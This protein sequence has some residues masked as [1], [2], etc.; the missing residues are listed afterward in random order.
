MTTLDSRIGRILPDLVAWRRDLHAHPEIAF[1]EHRTSA[2]IADKLRGFGLEAHTGLAGTGVVGVLRS[3]DG[4]MIGL[5]SDIDALPIEEA[6]GLPYASVHPGRMH[7]CGHDGHT[8]MLLGAARVL[9]EARP[10]SGTFVFVFQPAEENEGGA[11]AMV[12]EGL[13]SRFP[14]DAIY[15]M[16]NWPGLACGHIAVHSGPVM[17]AFDTFEAIVEGR[18][19]HAAMPDQGIDPITISGH[20]QA[21][22]QAIV[23]RS[24]SPTEPA[25]ISVTQ[26]HAGDTWNVIPDKVALRGTVRSFDPAVRDLLEAKMARRAEM[27]CAAFDASCQF[28]YTRRYPATINSARE[29][30]TARLAA[31]E[32]AGA[33]NVVTDRPPSMGAEDFA[34]MLEHKPGAYVWIGNGPDGNGR[35][36]HN[37]RYDFNDATL[38]HGVRF[39]VKLAEVSARAAGN[40]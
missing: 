14:V 19:S 10:K 7:A 39:W 37:P 27:I 12:E 17:A 4:P 21:A 32:A 9:A 20:L 30:A 8:A 34:F 36:L 26:I 25:V 5:R 28:T 15:G 16:H 2:F 33:D 24:V 23:S 38:P 22:W 35:I 11:R 31:L 3:G 40:A 13:F 1:Q 6:T 29:A 18:G